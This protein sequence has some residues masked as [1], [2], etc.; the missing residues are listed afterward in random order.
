MFKFKL[1]LY[2]SNDL[3]ALFLTERGLTLGILSA[4]TLSSPQLHRGLGKQLN[5]TD[6]AVGHEKKD[7]VFL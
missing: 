6:G 3:R 4:G 5:L 7:Y 2:K 1:G